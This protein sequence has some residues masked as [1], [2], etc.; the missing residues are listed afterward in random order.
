MESELTIY[1]YHVTSDNQ[2]QNDRYGVNPEL[3]SQFESLYREAQ[4]KRNKSIIE[5]LNQLIL[6]YPTVPIL[7]NYLSVAFNV[8]GKIDKSHE[9]NNWILKEH[10]DY[11]FARLNQAH[12]CIE[13]QEYDKV[14]ELLGES[15]EIKALYPDREIFHYS[16]VTSFYKCVVRYY[17]AMENEELAENRYNVMKTVAPD[18]P[19][20]LQAK[21]FLK[22]LPSNFLADFIKPTKNNVQVRESEKPVKHA[23]QKFN[24]A[25]VENLYRYGISIS[26]DTLK[27]IISLPQDTLATDLENIL[28]D[29]VARF[30]F[31]NVQI[32][33]DETHN[34]VLHS[35]CI[36]REIN[37]ENSLP[38]ILEFLQSREEIL[39]FYLGDHI[40]ET[41]WQC[42]YGLGQNSIDKLKDFLL[43]PKVSTYCKTAV[44][45]ALSQ[46]V[47]HHPDRRHE[48]I[49]VY[50]DVFK[51]YLNLDR[52]DQIIDGDF[53]GLCIADTVDCDF[54]E[55]IP[56]I[57]EMY[58]KG[59]VS[60]E[61][62][63]DFN[64]VMSE[65]SSSKKLSNR[66]DIYNIYELYNNIQLNWAGYNGE[67]E[68]SDCI[69]PEQ[70]VSDKIGRNE[71]CP[72]GSGKKYKKCCM[73]V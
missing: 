22:A 45:E 63:G 66:L 70:A 64:E 29:A 69:I 65:F 44:S 17:V 73:R 39:D 60:I 19:D 13:T 33:N 32:W 46:L 31:F 55:L 11:L 6:Q 68:N 54:H 16:E 43:L 58:N 15:M 36:L 7:K 38:K 71:S 10:P 35:I 37:A 30:E 23:A 50:S 42:I 21:R 51:A 62:C 18:H 14:P 67:L 41:V 72:C 24:H 40:T 57:Q 28:T 3:E 5:K 8:Q 4:N 34:F 9:V 53:L 27:S 20:T 12:R 56:R 47:F 26:H 2:L 52:E 59:I 1:G 61:I 49:A 48:I 25:E